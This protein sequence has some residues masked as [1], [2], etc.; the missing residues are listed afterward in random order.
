MKS[1]AFSEKELAS[2]IE[3]SAAAAK[4]AASLPTW[5]DVGHSLRAPIQRNDDGTV[6]VNVPMD[7]TTAEGQRA[8]G[9]YSELMEPFHRASATRAKS[10][11]ERE[12][13]VEVLGPGGEKRRVREQHAEQVERK[14]HRPRTSIIVPEMPWKRNKESA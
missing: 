12:P 13:H 5:D 7:P 2:I 9:A 8:L 1:P 11:R 10:V 4:P 6:E 14:F 3:D